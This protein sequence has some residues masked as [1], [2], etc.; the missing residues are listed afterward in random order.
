MTL[1]RT[2]EL[3]GFFAAHGVWCIAREGALVPMLA[4]ER[5]DGKR[6]MDRIALDDRNEAVAA[7][8]K[9][10][11]ENAREAVRAVL[12]YDAY[13]AAPWGKAEAI[14]LDARQYGP[15]PRACQM[16]VPYRGAR[17]GKGFAVYRPKLV[18]VQGATETSYDPIIEAF[19][20]G[21]STH[22]EGAAIWSDH[23]EESRWGPRDE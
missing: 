23:L 5:A 16:M 8:R 10:L 18:A 19:F 4:Y 22:Q 6:V 9:W 17:S 14:L 1:E 20:R 11:E 15:A 2:A 13:V 12:V 21:V 3:A 7:G